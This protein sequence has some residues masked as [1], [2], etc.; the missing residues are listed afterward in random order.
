MQEWGGGG[1]NRPDEACE[2]DLGD[3]MLAGAVGLDAGEG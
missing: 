2:G 3:G 1:V